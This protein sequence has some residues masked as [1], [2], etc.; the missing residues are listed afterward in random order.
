MH[1]YV[2]RHGETLWNVQKRLQGQTDIEL[3]E[4]G[5][6]LA[7]KTAESLSSVPFTV[8]FSSPLGRAKETARILLADRDVQVNEDD[9]L[10]EIS[11]GE[12]EGLVNDGTG[13]G[14]LKNYQD[15]F[16]NPGMYIPPS[17]GETLCSLCE[18]TRSFLE[19]LTHNHEL[20]K[21]TVLVATHG[22]AMRALLNSLREYELSDFWGRGVPKNCAVAVLE[23]HAGKAALVKA[24]EASASF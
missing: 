21:E 18:R 19:E 8:C 20:E 23:S 11:F 22:A 24:E 5:R 7:R 15:F 17:G 9:R 12:M 10:A 13:R 1:I 4:N 14:M 16:R 3:N 6:S 2:V